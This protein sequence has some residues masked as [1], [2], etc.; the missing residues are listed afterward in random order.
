M[1]AACIRNGTHYVDITGEPEFMEEMALKHHEEAKSK[2]V[3]VV[4]GCGFDSIPAELCHQLMQQKFEDE[5]LAL[6]R[7]NC[8]M[9]FTTPKPHKGGGH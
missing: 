4:H 9:S 7:I 6:E 1:V 2:G 3:I 8:Y 5:G